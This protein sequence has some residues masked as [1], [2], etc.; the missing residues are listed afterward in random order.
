MS[1]QPI[2]G[3]HVDAL[4]KAARFDPH[5]APKLTVLRGLRS[6]EDESSNWIVDQVVRR[7]R[8]MSSELEVADLYL[9]MYRIL[10]EVSND[11]D[12]ER[13]SPEDQFPSLLAPIQNAD[14]VLV[15]SRERCGFPDANTVR[16]LE[17]LGELAE[18]KSKE[19]PGAKIFDGAPCAVVV[20]GGCG[21]AHAALTLG[22]ALN[23]LGTIITSCG[24]LSWD[25]GRGKVMKDGDFATKLEK[26][27][28][29]LM[30]LTKAQRR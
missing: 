18:T 10:G 25:E 2:E 23:R 16:L 17:R 9:P 19:S 12:S 7:L 30:D 8:K 15:A 24:L 1:F 28:I 6:Y 29:D 27:A 20:H 21:A 26:V 4:R 13:F 3:I 22:A 14:I 5:R 11:P